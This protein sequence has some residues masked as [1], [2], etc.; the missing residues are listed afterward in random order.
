[1]V[2][3]VQGEKDAR[4][5]FS[6]ATEE[7]IHHLDGR[8]TLNELAGNCFCSEQL[9]NQSPLIPEGDLTVRYFTEVFVT[10]SE[11]GLETYY[12]CTTGE[13]FQVPNAAFRERAV[14]AVRAARALE[15]LWAE[16]VRMVESSKDLP[17]LA[18]T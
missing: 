11:F 5:W 15:V 8:L 14:D 13:Q 4:E 3:F 18:E 10:G 2:Q 17:R 9:A 6:R 16:L 1:M 12:D 7:E